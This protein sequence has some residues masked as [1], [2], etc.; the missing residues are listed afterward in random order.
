MFTIKH[1]EFIKLNNDGAI[2]RMIEKMRTPIIIDG[3][4]IFQQLVGRKGVYYLGVG[5]PNKLDDGLT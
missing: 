3:W 5:I 1:D 4:G 2:V